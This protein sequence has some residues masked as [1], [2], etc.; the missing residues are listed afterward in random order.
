MPS[1]FSRA[2][3]SSVA[4][5]S[6]SSQF[7][8]L[9]SSLKLNEWHRHLL[10]HTWKHSFQIETFKA[11]KTYPARDTLCLAS[12]LRDKDFFSHHSFVQ[13]LF[14]DETAKN[15]RRFKSNK[16][17]PSAVMKGV[18]L[19][20][21][22]NWKTLINQ[23]DKR[24]E[25]GIQQRESKFHYFYIFKR[26]SIILIIHDDKKKQAKHHSYRDVNTCS[27]LPQMSIL[28]LRATRLNF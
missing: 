3:G 9:L 25:S 6:F 26:V 5:A 10:R 15:S 27:I 2:F 17:R 24:E 22:C 18:R 11:S 4:V 7:L 21:S 20:M 14:E 12:V 23:L 16:K 1:L 28:V 13:W 8:V 19:S